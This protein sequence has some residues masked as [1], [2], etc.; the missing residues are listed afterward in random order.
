MR[1]N[2][3]TIKFLIDLFAIL[4]LHFYL[5]LACKVIALYLL[6]FNFTSN[7]FMISLSLVTT[8]HTITIEI[9]SDKF[10]Y[11]KVERV[12]TLLG[13]NSKKSSINNLPKH[14]KSVLI[15]GVPILFSSTVIMLQLWTGSSKYMK[16]LN[17]RCMKWMIF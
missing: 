14:Q 6:S 11:S 10:R 7:L 12:I 4:I 3:C 9:K 15:L 2:Y 13:S 16:E 17:K 5:L 1:N 8:L